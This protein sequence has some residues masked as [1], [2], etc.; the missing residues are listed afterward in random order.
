MRV[1]MRPWP[2]S[3]VVFVTE[4][5]RRRGFEIGVDLRFQRRLIAFQRQQKIG[6]VLDDL[7]GD[8]D[9]AAHGVDGDESA[10]ELPRLRPVDR[11]ATGMAVIS[12]VFSGTLSCARTRRALV[13]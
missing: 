4:F 10:F 6:L 2:F 8:V 9:L 12:L 3:T 7:G 1:S 13:A 5:V 11:A